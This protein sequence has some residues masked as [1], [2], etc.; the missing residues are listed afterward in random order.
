MEKIQGKQHPTTAAKQ[1]QEEAEDNIH[2][3]GSPWVR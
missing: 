2:L 3:S 1:V